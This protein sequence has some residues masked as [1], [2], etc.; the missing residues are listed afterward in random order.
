VDA[1]TRLSLVF[2]RNHP[3]DAAR[4]FERH[5]AGEVVSFLEGADSPVVASALENTLPVLASE[6]LVL[7]TP[8]RATEAL[9]ILPTDVALKL[10]RHLGEEA[11]GTILGALPGEHRKAYESL[12]SYPEG[13]AGAMMNPFAFVL[14]EDLTVGEALRRVREAGRERFYFPYVVDRQQKLVGLL[15]VRALMLANPDDPLAKIMHREVVHLPATATSS[16]LER[17]PG[18]RAFQSLPVVDEAGVLIGAIP[19]D[20][21]TLLSSRSP[22][23][24]AGAAVADTFLLMGTAYWTCLSQLAAQAASIFGSLLRP[25][26]AD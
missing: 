24:G 3:A 6:Y 14:P 9:Q 18:W 12:L 7:L 1:V 20:R 25:R 10:L 2:A 17:I 13:T 21:L 19:N 8:S 15:T 22:Q 26:N 23:A 4:V 16:H 11:R 5:P